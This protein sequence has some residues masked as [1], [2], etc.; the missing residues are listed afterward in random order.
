MTARFSDVENVYIYID[1][2][3]VFLMSISIHVIFFI[4]ASLSSLLAFAFYP[5]IADSKTRSRS[6]SS[7]HSLRAVLENKLFKFTPRKDSSYRTFDGNLFAISRTFE[8]R[9]ASVVSIGRQIGAA[10]YAAG[11]NNFSTRVN[12]VS[13]RNPIVIAFG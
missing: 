1:L 4:R 10:L 9:G 5:A 13:L 2:Q 3:Y 7:K 8:N 6:R 12:P 11:A